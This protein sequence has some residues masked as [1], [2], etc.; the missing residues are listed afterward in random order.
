LNAMMDLPATLAPQTR[1]R[2]L[3]SLLVLSFLL[4][5]NCLFNGFVFDD[6][7][8][9]QLNPYVH[10]FGYVGKL[11]GTSLLAQQGKQAVPNFYRPLTNFTFLLGYK[12]FGE[13]PLGYHLF[14]L[15]L[16]C[17]ATWLVFSVGTQLFRNDSLGLIAA[18]LFAIHPVHV[19]SV[20]W[21]DAMGDPLITV[22]LLISF[23]F[24]LQLGEHGNKSPIASYIG[25]IL[26]FAAGVFTKETAVIFPFLATIFE[27]FYRSDRSATN[28]LQKLSRYAGLW[29]TLLLYIVARVAAVGQFIPS[30]LH[31]EVSR[32]EA[33]YSALALIGQ[34]AHKLVWPIPLIAFCPFQKSTS[35][36]E[37]PVLFGIAV[38]FLCVALFIFLWRH[39][40]LYSFALLWV[41][42]SIG[43]PLNTRW[44]TASVF[45]ERY[46]YLASVAFSW[47][48]AGGLLWIWNRQGQRSA[49]P[50]WILAGA[51]G[52]LTCFAAHA[53][54]SRISDW[55]SDRA[56]IVSTLRVLPNSPH[57][58]V[59]YGIFRWSEGA[60]AEAERE[61]HIA[62]SLN[63]ESVEAMAEL[64]RASL[65][66]KQYDQALQ[67]LHKAISLKPNFATARVLLGR[68][69]Q[70]QGNDTAAASEF[71][72][73]LAVHPNDADAMIALGNLY[74]RQGRLHDAL[75]Q[76]RASVQI[77]PLLD[78]WISLGK[79]YDQL[80]QSD[81]A[82]DAWTQVVQIERFNPEAHRAL[83]QIYLSRSQW[84][85]AQNEFEMCLLM[86]PKDPV[87]LAGLQ[88]IKS[89]STPRNNPAT[90]QQ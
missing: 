47:L 14:S 68:V 6:H 43:P 3:A 74:F 4:Y 55:R 41:A 5:A 2:L 37:P 16:H 79:I 88:K 26:A 81:L 52:L 69:Y 27:H 18:F 1:N 24:Y 11:F 20:A 64:G 22:L 65:E 82:F 51:T 48:V 38:L 71:L 13:S 9:I 56:L 85:A 34:Y 23:W 77:Q 10:S 32:T 46:L 87:A 35:L 84:N 28:W 75:L 67:W 58:H 89:S 49:F 15:L 50:R 86:N 42:F 31:S 12:L 78:T 83:A 66:K 19:E 29:L 40:R 57:T 76:F 7:S 33:V 62:L 53:S 73:A 45:A 36:F 72:R 25:T 80:G 90:T 59:Q 8:Q 21:I 17:A 63:P 44:M 39:A 30:Q 61:W 70:A 54:I 60:Q